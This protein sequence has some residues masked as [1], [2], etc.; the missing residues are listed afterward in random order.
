MYGTALLSPFSDYRF[1][2]DNIF[3]VDPLYTLPLIISYSALIIM[4]RDHPARSKWNAFGLGI[5]SIYMIITFVNHGAAIN[6]LKS[7][8]DVTQKNVNEYF[9]IPTLF[10]SVLWTVTVKED[11]GFQVG[12]YSI[13]D[14]NETPAMYYISRNDSLIPHVPDKEALDKLIK[15]SKGFYSLTQTDGRIYFNDLRFG[16]VEGWK[17]PKSAFAFSFDLSA[18]ADNQMVVQQGRIAGSAR[19]VITGMWERMKGNQIRIP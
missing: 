9:A 12:Y 17:D 4:K 7:T 1:S 8:V 2:F 13:F 3:V 19:E 5:S 14:K 15:F 18:D 10:N 6:A 16:Q 11:Q